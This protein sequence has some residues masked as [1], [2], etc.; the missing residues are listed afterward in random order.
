V[1]LRGAARASALRDVVDARN[2]EH[3]DDQQDDVFHV[4]TLRAEHTGEHLNPGTHGRMILALKP[5]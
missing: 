2:Y 3:E 1:F 4:G 5:D